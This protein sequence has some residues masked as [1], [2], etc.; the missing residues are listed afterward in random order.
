MEKDG[1]LNCQGQI[2]VIDDQDSDVLLPDADHFAL[3][4]SSQS[5]RG[6]FISRSLNPDS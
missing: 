5:A 3:F 6:L 4:G 1:P 2:I